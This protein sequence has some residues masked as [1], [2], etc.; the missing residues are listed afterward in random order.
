MYDID[1][2]EDFVE[3]DAPH[4]SSIYSHRVRFHIAFMI[5]QQWCNQQIRAMPEFYVVR[6]L[7]ADA[8]QATRGRELFAMLEYKGVFNASGTLEW[9][10]D[11]LPVVKLGVTE[12]GLEGKY[13]ANVQGC[14]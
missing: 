14:D 12:F 6:Q 1:V 11:R 5:Y 2:P 9:S 4:R 7:L 3:K 13:A 10:V 8:S